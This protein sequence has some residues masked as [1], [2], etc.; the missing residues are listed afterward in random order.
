MPEKYLK[1]GMLPFRNSSSFDLALASSGS[2][3]SDGFLFMTVE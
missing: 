3:A 1:V 2:A